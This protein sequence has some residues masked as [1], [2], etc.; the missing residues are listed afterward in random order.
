MTYQYLKDAQPEIL[1][2]WWRAIQG[3]DHPPDEKLVAYSPFHFDRGPRARMCRCDQLVELDSE[4]AAWRLAEE[5]LRRDTGKT[6]WVSGLDQDGGI[7]FLIAGALA[8]VREDVKD[9]RSLAYRLGVGPV[10]RDEKPQLSELRFQRLMRAEEPDDF[11]MQLRRALK[12]G[13]GRVDVVTLTDDLV[14]W[15]TERTQSNQRSNGMKFRWARDYYLKRS[16]Q[17]L[18]PTASVTD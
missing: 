14:A 11:F 7:L 12:I 17:A 16:D 1:R 6:T 18:I 9:T 2:A 3:E 5:L 15:S 4:S 8:L 10:A 13:G